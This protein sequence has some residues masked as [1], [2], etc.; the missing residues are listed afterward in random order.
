MKR[1][2]WL[3]SS[4]HEEQDQSGLRLG[5]PR[6]EATTSF[7]H[8]AL[9][10]E[11]GYARNESVLRRAVDVRAP[12]QYLSD[13]MAARGSKSSLRQSIIVCTDRLGLQP[14]NRVELLSRRCTHKGQSEKDG[15]F[16]LISPLSQPRQ[17]LVLEALYRTLVTN[18]QHLFLILRL[19]GALTQGVAMEAL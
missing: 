1:N 8:I 19:A 15:A 9:L 14:S 18:D 11:I 10:G 12:F 4:T 3:D 6:F 2:I 17:Q 7:E 13:G 16:D 5:L